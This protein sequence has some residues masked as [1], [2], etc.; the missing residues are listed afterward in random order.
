MYHLD[1][2]KI[3]KASWVD[4]IWEDS[5]PILLCGEFLNHSLRGEGGKIF[6]I[7]HVQMISNNFD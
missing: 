7:R 3:G 5:R 1:M 4:S 2:L 6:F